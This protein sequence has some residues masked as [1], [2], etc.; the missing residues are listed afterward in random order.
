[1]KNSNGGLTMR[2]YIKI[3][4]SIFISC[5]M[6]LPLT[7]KKYY[8]VD[9]K[10]KILESSSPEYSKKIIKLYRKNL[11]LK[12]PKVFQK[13]KHNDWLV[14]SIYDI[15]NNDEI[16]V[17]EEAHISSCGRK[18]IF[19]TTE[20][21]FDELFEVILWLEKNDFKIYYWSII[22]IYMHYKSSLNLEQRVKIL[23]SKTLLFKND[24]NLYG[25]LA[26]VFRIYNAPCFRKCRSDKIISP[27]IQKNLNA[28]NNTTYNEKYMIPKLVIFIDCLVYN[29]INDHKFLKKRI[30]YF[31]NEPPQIPQK[32]NSL[33]F[34]NNDKDYIYRFVTSCTGVKVND[35][36]S[37][38]HWLKDFNYSIEKDWSYNEK[39]HDE[40]MKKAA[41]WGLSLE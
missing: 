4:L 28:L 11:E 33:F 34:G 31:F 1:M 20:K 8:F 13:I 37:F 16:S 17:L 35:D 36:K 23:F 22:S 24:F 41:K 12:Q 14:F 5:I 26:A 38:Y 25:T 21:K 10:V 19:T 32:K 30:A 6:W 3:A 18:K 39:V 7:A 29:Y 9:E 2:I 27:L 15:L 40:N